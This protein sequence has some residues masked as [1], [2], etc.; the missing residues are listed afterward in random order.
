MDVPEQL[1][2]STDH[3]WVRVTDEG[4][5]VVGITDYAQD[6]LGDVG[7]GGKISG[8]VK[9]SVCRQFLQVYKFERIAGHRLP[10]CQGICI[11]F[12]ECFSLEA[13]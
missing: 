8:F 11:D 1:R 13:R 2:Y 5:C 12:W 6:A 3:E 9:G 7:V 10:S 4:T